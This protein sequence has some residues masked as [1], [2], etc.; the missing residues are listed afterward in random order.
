MIPL[1]LIYRILLLSVFPHAAAAEDFPQ[2]IHAYLQQRVAEKKDVGIVVGLVDEHGSTVVSCGSMNADSDREVNGDTL[3]GIGSITKT[4][5]AL[6]LQ[7]MVD[8]REMRLHDPVANYLPHSVKVP[9][10]CGRQIT[11]LDLATHT[12]GLPL[13]PDNFDT[14]HLDEPWAGY[15]VEKLYAFVSGCR[16]N[17]KP[18]TKYE[19]STVGMALLGQAIARKAGTNYEALV[20]TRICQPLGMASTRITLTPTLTERLARGYKSGSAV[21]TPDWGVLM[22]G[23][24]L[25]STA[26]DLLKYLSANLGLNHSELTPL[27]EKTHAARF[28]AYLSTDNDLH[29]DVAL[30]WMVTS[31]LRGEIIQH[32][33]LSGG[34][35]SF[36]GFDPNWRHG[37][38]VWSNSRD[39]DVPRIGM[40]LFQSEWR[41]DRRPQ[42]IKLNSRIYDLYAGQYQ[43]SPNLALG[44]LVLQQVLLNTPKVVI[45]VLA[46]LCLGVL[47]LSTWRANRR[48]RS[49]ALGG[50]ALGGCL[51]TAFLASGLSHVIC[52]L[53]HPGVVIRHEG[54]RLFAEYTLNVDR[55]SAPVAAKFFSHIP[56]KL[57]PHQTVELL[58]ESNT[59]FFDRLTGLP[60]IFSRDHRGKATG[61][62]IYL[63]GKP[64]AYR[65]TS[66]QPSETK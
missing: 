34:F 58:P 56:I 44:M 51:A 41:T 49:I 35:I 23:A 4:F 19:Y 16:L 65:K 64:F 54:D 59:H 45:C 20:L 21:P 62:T 48:Q 37:V 53:V 18:G 6:L 5:T 66:N 33:G 12:S 2:A 38:V 27:M 60:V 36:V 8:R 22:A 55:A 32:G 25:H 28:H 7:D 29:T 63:Q 1:L 47:L 15:S 42:A 10:F 43:L 30:G 17:W 9:E 57:F 46:G 61:A 31:G 14:N 39:F 26:N 40:L 13:F 50:A 3:F 52:S 11:L 24:G